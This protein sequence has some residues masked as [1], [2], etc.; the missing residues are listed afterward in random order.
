MA[1]G[2]SVKALV[3]DDVAD[4]RR[5][6]CELL[7]GI[8]VDVEEVADGEQALTSLEQDL[9]DCAIALSGG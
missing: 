8:G 9:P 4:N 5:I 7:I 2:N 3:V 1:E 6:L